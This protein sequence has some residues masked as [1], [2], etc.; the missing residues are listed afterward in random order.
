MK[1]IISRVCFTLIALTSGAACFAQA[2]PVKPIHII[3]PF[4]AGGP[5]DVFARVIAQKLADRIGQSVVVEN[6][7]GADG[8]IG[9][10]LVA[11]AAPDGYTL[12]MLSLGHTAQVSMYKL[13]Y[14]VKSFAPIS[15]VVSIPLVFVVGSKSKANTLEEFIAMAKQQPGALN[16][17]SGGNGT[18][19]HL[20]MEMLMNA[21]KIKMQHIAYKGM[22]P[23]LTDL[24]S[25]QIDA[26]VS[27]TA[28]AAPFIQS[29]QMKALAV[30]TEGRYSPLPNIPTVAELGYPSYRVDTWHGLVAPAGTPSSVT[31]LLNKH[32]RDILNLPDVK[33]KFLQLGATT[34]GTTPEQFSSIIGNEIER[35]RIVVDEAQI[36]IE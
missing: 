6:K 14:E 27:P 21:T 2:F 25:G 26:L 8:R 11:Q 12:L 32:V 31:E 19:Q 15:R 28:S 22:G 13:P 36:K 17:A 33:E 4:L 34:A 23:A 18:S 24:M 9:A 16:F 30:T 7:P 35:W 10:R 1:K 3:S 20:A 29:G 5:N